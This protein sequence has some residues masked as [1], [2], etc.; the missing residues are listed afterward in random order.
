MRK[1]TQEKSFFTKVKNDII[2]VTDDNDRE[3]KFRSLYENIL[4]DQYVHI[5]FFHRFG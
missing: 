2:L 4:P 3:I 5:T 1:I